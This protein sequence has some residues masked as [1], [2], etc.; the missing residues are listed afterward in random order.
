MTRF[1]YYVATTLDGFIADEHDSLDW[2]LTQP[3]DEA[4]AFNYSDFIT[5]IGALVMGAS[6][7]Q[8]VLDHNAE[9][10]EPWAYTQ[11]TWVFTHRDL[12]AVSGD[13]RIVAGEATDFRQTLVDA[14]AGKDVCRRGDAG[15]DDTKAPAPPSVGGGRRWR[16]VK[17]C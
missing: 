6:T 16:R 15:C 2:L 4:G 17:R 11:P 12:T 7:Y 8:W 13:V 14:A 10:G 9:T 5:D 1:R 3:I